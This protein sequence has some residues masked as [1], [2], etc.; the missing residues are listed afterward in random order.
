MLQRYLKN[1]SKPVSTEIIMIMWDFY[2]IFQSTG[3]RAVD[4]FYVISSFANIFQQL[5]LVQNVIWQLYSNYSLRINDFII[6]Q[7]F[8][9]VSFV[10]TKRVELNKRKNAKCITGE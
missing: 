8:K 1:E 5:N 4:T 7:R 3:F 9:P 10:F 2:I 6:Y